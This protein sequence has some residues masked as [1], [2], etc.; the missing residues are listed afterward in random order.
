MTVAKFRNRLTTAL[1]LVGLGLLGVTFVQVRFGLLPLRRIEKGL[2]LIRSGDA[3]KL[4]GRLPA[5][6]EPCKASSMRSSSPTWMW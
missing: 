5:E 1:A 6:I 4:A 2:A 3:R